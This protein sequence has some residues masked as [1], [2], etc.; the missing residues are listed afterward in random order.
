MGRQQ[1]KGKEMSKLLKGA[2]VVLMIAGV[3]GCVNTSDIKTKT[4]KS[5]KVDMEGYKTYQIV[6]GSG[7]VD[8]T[9]RSDNMDI[10]AEMR[11]MM[12][13]EL[14]KK[15]KMKVTENPDF[16]VAYAAGSDMEAVKVKLDADGKETVEARPEAA[17][18]LVLI[19]A[20]TGAIIAI[21]EAEGEAKNL[22]PEDTKKRLS[23]AI[24][25]MFEG[26]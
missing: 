16:Y 11:Q 20:Q 8:D 3:T 1:T 19:D 21:S 12:N 18:L 2:M 7:I 9:K 14:A 13:T 6:E 26:L 24:N 15:G 17:I 5:V 22:S 25:K 10:N 4:V 23:Y